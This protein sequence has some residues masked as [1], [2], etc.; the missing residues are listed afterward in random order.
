MAQ[1]STGTGDSSSDRLER[2]VAHR[3]GQR[4]DCSARVDRATPPV[5]VRFDSHARTLPAG[6]ALRAGYLDCT[7]PRTMLNRPPMPMP[8]AAQ[9]NAGPTANSATARGSR[10]VCDRMGEH[11]AIGISVR[12]VTGCRDLCSTGIR[13]RSR[14]AKVQ[15]SSGAIQ[16]ER[17]RAVVD[18]KRNAKHPAKVLTFSRGRAAGPF[19]R[20][21]QRSAPGPPRRSRGSARQARGSARRT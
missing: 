4:L 8:C 15:G 14:D 2:I 3:F 10:N 11:L 17:F 1:R 9:V 16:D 6:E 19:R 13:V 18:R 21:L 12:S 7:S 20:Y 5:A